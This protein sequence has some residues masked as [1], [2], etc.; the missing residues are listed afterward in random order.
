VK[1]GQRVRAIL[2]CGFVAAMV[3]GACSSDSSGGP[4]TGGSGGHGGSAGTSGGGR[5]GGGGAGG[6]AGASV[7]AAAGAGGGVAGLVLSASL[8]ADLAERIGLSMIWG[9][10]A[11]NHAPMPICRDKKEEKDLSGRVRSGLG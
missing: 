2:L 10:H 6:A 9:N 11:E 1:T 5:G 8:M 7:A 4:G 3:A